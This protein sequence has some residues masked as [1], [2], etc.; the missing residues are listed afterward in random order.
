LD[1][2]VLEK[3]AVL[4]PSPTR[5]GF[6]GFGAFARLV[7]ALM[8]FGKESFQDSTSRGLIAEHD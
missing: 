6:F 8:S 1:E 5:L 4:K 3:L 2:G 7:R